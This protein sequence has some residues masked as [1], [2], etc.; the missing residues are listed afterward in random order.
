MRPSGY[1]YNPDLDEYDEQEVDDAFDILL[2]GTTD[3][4]QVEV[5][6]GIGVEHGLAVER[7]SGVRVT[8]SLGA[9][10]EPLPP[11]QGPASGRSGR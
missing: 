2:D 9:A 1:M 6:L 8:R 11:T 4:L 5:D 7:R 10:R 3:L